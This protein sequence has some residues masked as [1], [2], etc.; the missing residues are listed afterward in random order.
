MRAIKDVST[1]NKNRDVPAS[2]PSGAHME[3]C[4][5][6][7]PKPAGMVDRGASRNPRWFDRRK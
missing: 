7:I 3:Q 5:P 6:A 1:G 4:V 2:P